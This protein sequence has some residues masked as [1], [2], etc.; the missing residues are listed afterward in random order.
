MKN[1]LHKIKDIVYHNRFV[2]QMI[3]ILIISATST[4]L[5]SQTTKGTVRKSIK[6]TNVTVKQLVDNLGTEFK[7]SFYIVDDQIPNKIV[8]VDLKNA[9]IKE[10]LDNAFL[11]KDIEYI[12]KNNNITISDKKVL[13][14]K[15]NG[16][17]KKITGRVV[18]NKE[19]PIIGASVIVKGSK[20]AT[21]TD[22]NGNFSLNATN[23]SLL[24]VSYI[25]YLS[26]EVKVGSQANL[27]IKLEENTE[28]LNEVVVVGYGTQKKVNVTGSVSTVN[29]SVISKSPVSNITNSLVGNLPGLRATMRSG[30]PG[31]DESSIDIRGFGDALIIVD[32]VPSSFSQL[33]PAEIESV[34]ILKDGSAAIYGVRSANGVVLVTTKKGATAKPKITYNTYYGVQSITRYPKF[35]NA[36]EYAELTDESEINAGRVPVFGK[37]KVQKY[38]EGKEAGYEGTD[39][40]DLA[41]R[42][43]TPQKYH[44][45]TATGGTETTKYF[46]SLGYFDQSGMWKSDDTHFRRYNF[47]SNI[48]SKI[49][50]QLTVEFN[51]SGRIEKRDAP[52]TSASLLMS[53]IARTFPTYEAYANGNPLYLARTNI[54]VNLLASM[55]KDKVG[56]Y[57]EKQKHLN[58]IISLNY[59]VP[60]IKGLAAKAMYSYQTASVNEKSWT[61]KYDLYKYDTS[62][63]SY[64][65]SYTGNDPTN[66]YLSNNQGDET[67][68]QL[69]LNYSTSLME[70][71]NIKAL[72]LFERSEGI[73]SNFNAYR[74]FVLD[75]LDQMFAGASQNKNN[76]GSGSESANM[77]YVGRINYDYDNKYLFEA[78]FR[79]DGSY[80]FPK[81]SRFGFFPTFSAGWR[82]SNEDFLKDNTVINNLK[83]RASW[84][85]M[86][87]DGGATPF[88]W[89]MGYRFPEGSYIF[90]DAITQGLVSTGVPNNQLTWYTATTSNL[91]FEMGFFKN[92]LTLD[93]DVF[94]RERKG[95]LAT[96]NLTLPDSYG[97]TLP[98]ENLNSDNTRGFEFVVGY[99][100]KIGDLEYKVSA[101][102]TWTRSRNDYVEQASPTSAYTNWRNN[103]SNRWNNR[104]WG[105]KAVGQFQSMDEIK[106][107][108]IQDSK[109]NTTLL[110]G[111]I[112]YEDLNKDG[113]IN[114]N[115]YAVIGR[116]ATPELFYGLTLAAA[117]KGFDFSM[118]LQGAANFNVYFSEELQNP[119]FNNANSYAFLTDRWHKADMYDANSEWIP[120]KYP[121]TRANGIDNNKYTSSFWLKDASYLRLKTLE[122][123]YSIP[124]NLISKIGFEQV[125]F[126]FSGQNLFTFDKIKYIDPEAPG[127][128][129]RFYPQQRVMTIG[130][131]VQL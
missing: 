115:D 4:N 56:Y 60:F 122:I 76:D 26:S 86:G 110:P 29:G 27:L 51:L 1:K 107:W 47:R 131:N 58:G 73:Y 65:S 79:Y 75:A 39:W 105:Y 97:A 90:G 54:D 2:C 80:K 67:Q 37:E 31:F 85:K 74:E 119:F 9:T 70:K 108:A 72:L 25:G 18:D 71:H 33:D 83:L 121:T 52:K 84:G 95:L 20:V 94:F 22:V 5:F 89:I 32:G 11:N 8:S 43:Y 36:A 30:E 16:A 44:N 21:I 10:I 63:D 106:S 46:L 24:T 78:G 117:Y 82:L 28:L 6:M 23:Q 102:T 7:Y 35:A 50:K 17:I 53:Q 111:D 87:D 19:E 91:G 100:N 126:Y 3:I 42:K 12:I 34:S 49:G 59:D 77:G 45:M 69:S 57:N 124:K 92:K 125:R 88:S 55:E 101:N 129:G 64:E 13:N 81:D 40:Y 61:K 120:G 66:L 127:G 128:R 113:V 112:K 93:M 130:L 99:N 114:G 48:S 62:T 68:L 103:G 14:N 109:A 15:K 118:L 98:Q 38:R 123:G 41:I 96:R 116:G 104:Y